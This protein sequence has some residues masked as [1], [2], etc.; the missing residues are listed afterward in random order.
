MFYPSSSQ[1]VVLKKRITI[2]NAKFWTNFFR[3]AIH[4]VGYDVSKQNTYFTNNLSNG[5]KYTIDDDV[6]VIPTPGHTLQH[7]SVIVK[8]ENM[9]V[10]AIAGDLFEKREDLINS[11][12]WKSAGSQSEKKQTKNRNRVLQLADWI[13]PGHG[14]M[15]KVPD[16]TESHKF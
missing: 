14:P 12:I 2:F 4:I 7:V 6:E 9:G 16:F 10:V 13:V 8:T 15:F 3:D 5:G 11:S 1:T